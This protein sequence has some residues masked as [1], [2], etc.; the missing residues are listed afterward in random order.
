MASEF[1]L[2]AVAVGLM[3]YES[4][5]SSQKEAKKEEALNNRFTTMESVIKEQNETIS[6]L[7]NALEAASK[8]KLTNETIGARLEKASA[9]YPFYDALL[10]PQESSALKF[11]YKEMWGCVSG[12][13]SGLV[14]GNIK[15]EEKILS[16]AP[17]IV[18]QMAASTAGVTFVPV[19]PESS[20]SEI[21]TVLSGS[22]SKA[23]IMSN[24]K[25]REIVE[26][27]LDY[28]PTLT[29]MEYNEMFKDT[30]YPSLKYLISTGDAQEPGI[31]LYKEFV[32]QVNLLGKTVTSSNQISTLIPSK[33]G[34][35]YGYTHA[36]L[37]NTGDALFEMLGLKTHER[38]SF[39]VAFHNGTSY[40]LYLGCLSHGA[41]VVVP[42]AEFSAETAL[43]TVASDKC[44]TLF[45]TGEQL[46][47]ILGNAKLSKFDLSTLTTVVVCGS[48]D[49]A[50][51]KDAETK[52]KASRVFTLDTVQNYPGQLSG[53][54]FNQSGA[55]RILPGV[56]SKIDNG[57]LFTKGI[58]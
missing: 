34:Q 29:R 7:Q 40:A 42:N 18:T 56:E 49:A 36:S 9:K 16:N 50:T 19:A 1:F 55:G 51:I 11:T 5:R 58:G 24:L 41:L 25:S 33:D 37:I 22:S 28:F 39:N 57:V 46:Q 6:Q 2:L 35:F 14:E 15:P 45:V 17:Q 30:R 26:E 31:D 54:V 12:L 8:F 48:A 20:M 32:L 21:G 44:S 4:D 3:V 47:A 38:V 27:A 52:L 10:F 53:V 13:A 23:F 43:S